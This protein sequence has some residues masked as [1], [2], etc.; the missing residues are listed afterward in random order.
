MV[1]KGIKDS[2][3]PRDQI[4]IT[5]KL[6]N[7]KHDPKDVES[8]LDD[9]LKDLG[10]DYVDLYLMHW[11]SG[12]KPGDTPVPKDDNG[13]AILGDASYVDT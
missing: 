7:N 10:V 8:S 13:K 4:F 2:G 9:S 5:T 6:W 1:G 12:F 3:V 11:P